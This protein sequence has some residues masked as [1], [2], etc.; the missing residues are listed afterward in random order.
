MRF[1]QADSVQEI[2]QTTL[3]RRWLGPRCLAPYSP[4]YQHSVLILGS[5]RETVQRLL[6]ASA[7]LKLKSQLRLRALHHETNHAGKRQ[8]RI[9][10][11]RL[12]GKAD[13][14]KVVGSRFQTDSVRPGPHQG[15][16][17]NSIWWCR[18]TK[19]FGDCLQLQRSVVVPTKRRGRSGDLSRS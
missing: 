18:R 3:A 16:G 15:G 19:P 11:N 2:R 14:S 10:W 7:K 1:Q 6:S 12:H 13:R 5:L 9:C 4:C 17:A 8:A